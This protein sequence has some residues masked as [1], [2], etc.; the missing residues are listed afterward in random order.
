MRVSEAPDIKLISILTESYVTVPHLQL[1]Y[2]NY[3]KIYRKCKEINAH[4]CLS[5]PVTCVIAIKWKDI[6]EP[7]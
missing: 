4:E 3:V 7:Y 5:V 1:H 6:Q 2:V